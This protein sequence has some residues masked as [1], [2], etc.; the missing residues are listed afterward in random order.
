MPAITLRHTYAGAALEDHLLIDLLV[1]Y[2]HGT[3]TPIDVE[4][5]R[6]CRLIEKAYAHKVA[7][8]L[9]RQLH[10]LGQPVT[11]ETITAFGA[12]A[13]RVRRKNL[14]LS[15]YLAHTL[16]SL[17]DEN[18][19]A[20]PFKGAA[21]ARLAH[22]DPA[23]RQFEDLD[24]LVDPAHIHRAKNH[25]IAAGFALQFL[26]EHVRDLPLPRDHY[27]FQFRNQRMQINLELHW[28]TAWSRRNLHEFRV[29]FEQLWD[30]GAEIT[31]AKTTMRTLSLEHTIILLCIDSLK[32]T[33]VK[34][35]R[36]L[37]L[38]ALIQQ[39]PALNWDRLLRHAGEIGARRIVETTLAAVHV[40]L[41]TSPPVKIATSSWLL[42]KLI[43]DYYLDVSLNQ[44]VLRYFRSNIELRD[45]FRQKGAYVLRQFYTEEGRD[46]VAQFFIR[47]LGK[48]SQAGG[49]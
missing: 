48:S 10:R 7:P 8:I 6:W 31:L 5:V 32:E 36:L 43:G 37:D 17:A 42:D 34:L 27:H 19:R 2:L 4:P 24:I 13:E 18:I 40:L 38:A 44:S 49:R 23:L 45:T 29:S 21:L 14:F 16:K 28:K 33:R 26:P 9:Y 22:G 11:S 25:M 39:H 3:S 35:G 41:H 15:V 20:I 46:R 47:S 30:S 1:G 12:W